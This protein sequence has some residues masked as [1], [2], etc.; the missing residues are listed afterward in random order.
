[1]KQTLFFRIFESVY[2]HDPYFLKCTLQSFRIQVN[3]GTWIQSKVFAYV[4]LCNL[5][6]EDA[7]NCNIKPLFDVGSNVSHLKQ[8][9]F[10]EN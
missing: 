4:I 7:S 10:F 1:M 5:I 6:I 2:A 8:R 3:H 9:L